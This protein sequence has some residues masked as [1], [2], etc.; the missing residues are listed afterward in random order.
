MI[1]IVVALKYSKAILAHY[2]NSRYYLTN[3]IV[4]GLVS[5]LFLLIIWGLMRL[6]RLEPF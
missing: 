5:N 2:A 3:V 4:E 6:C 1:H